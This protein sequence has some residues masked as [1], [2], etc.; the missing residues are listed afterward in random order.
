MNENRSAILLG[1]DH[2]AYRL[3][4]T[5]KAHILKLGIEVEDAGLF[6]K[7]IRVDQGPVLK[8]IR[9]RAQG[10]AFRINKPMSHNKVTVAASL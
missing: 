3:K 8:R 2:A 6:I 9:P 10:R 1:S 7:E 4:E 5:I